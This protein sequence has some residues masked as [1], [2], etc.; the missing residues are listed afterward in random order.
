MISGIF[1]NIGYATCPIKIGKLV[2]GLA[3]VISFSDCRKKLHIQ[4]I[5]GNQHY[6]WIALYFSCFFLNLQQLLLNNEK[7]NFVS[8]FVYIIKNGVLK[9]FPVYT[10][11]FKNFIFC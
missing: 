4:T 2:F 9:L 10:P 1:L 7:T 5:N 6:H 11:F 3:L 8:Y